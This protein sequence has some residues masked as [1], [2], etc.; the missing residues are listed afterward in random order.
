MITR[1]CVILLLGLFCTSCTTLKD[2]RLFQKNE[3][4]VLNEYGLIQNSYEP[5]RLQ[6][7][8]FV[9]VFIETNDPDAKE[10]FGSQN[11]NSSGGNRNVSSS[12]QS[13]NGSG[14]KIQ[15]DGY[16]HLLGL[17]SIY[18]LGL[19]QEQATEKVQDLLDEIYNENMAIAR[20]YVESLQFTVLGEVNSP[21]IKNTHESTINLFEAIA[22][23]GDLKNT[24]DRKNV[25]LWRQYPEG[26]KRVDIDLTREDIINSPYFYLHPNDYIAVN[27]TVEKIIGFGRES[28]WQ[29]FSRF[30]SILSLGISTYAIVKSL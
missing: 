18:L 5:Y 2:L 28:A 10:F 3:N 24:A 8:D 20:V 25:H 12:N 21:G 1:I 9:S 4:T 17:G 11:L 13:G 6:I 14:L 27:P 7:D 19:T 22:L 16:I 26:I 23:C 15:S 29:D 30:A